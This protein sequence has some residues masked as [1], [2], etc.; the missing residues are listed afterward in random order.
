MKNREKKFWSV[1]R[2]VF[3]DTKI[4]EG[5]EGQKCAPA[6]PILQKLQLSRSASKKYNNGIMRKQQQL[7]HTAIEVPDCETVVAWRDSGSKA[8][9]DKDDKTRR[10]NMS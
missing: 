10:K 2:P 9:S 3:G 5:T 6:S 4:G 7:L 8:R 1:S